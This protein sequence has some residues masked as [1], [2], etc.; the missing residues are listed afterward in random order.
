MIACLAMA[1]Y[2]LGWALLALRGPSTL[3]VGLVL[4]GASAQ[5][6][7]QARQERHQ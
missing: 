7:C 3:V 2:P 4:V 1:A 5:M 6:A